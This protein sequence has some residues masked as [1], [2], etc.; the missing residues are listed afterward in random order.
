MMSLAGS[1]WLSCEYEMVSEAR[2]ML[3]FHIQGC[4][5]HFNALRQAV[6]AAAIAFFEDYDLPPGTYGAQ[7]RSAYAWQPDFHASMLAKGAQVVSCLAESCHV[8]GYASPC[9]SR[10]A[11]I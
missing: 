8:L 3:S 9:D 10:S 5:T 2:Q 7:S 6:L 4:C 11:G 1:P